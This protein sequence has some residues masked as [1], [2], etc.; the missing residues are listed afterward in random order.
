MFTV[1]TPNSF[2]VS[3]LILDGNKDSITS[4]SVNGGI[5]NIAAGKLVIADGAVLRNSVT[6][7][8]GGAVYVANGA[9]V[10]MTGGE[11]TGNEAVNGGAVYVEAGATMT[12]K[13]GKDASNNAT[14][15]TITG[16]TAT[17]AGA[18]IY[19]D[20][21]DTAAAKKGATL[22]L[23]GNPSFGGTGR[24]GENVDAEII[25][26]KTVGDKIV[27]IGN[28]LEGGLPEGT[29]NGQKEYTKFR[30]DIYVAGYLGT[31][32][33]GAAVMP[34]PATAIVVTGPI[35]SDAGSIWVA[36]EKPDADEANNHYEMLKQFAVFA[37][38]IA[39]DE[40]T[41]QVFRNAWDDE[42]TGCG[43][44]Y[45]TG[46]EGDNLTDED[47]KTWKCIYWTGGF[48]FVF[49]KI[50]PNGDAL[51]GA[52]FTLYLSNGDHTA[53]L[54]EKDE[55]ENDVEVAFQQTPEGGGDK[56]P[57]TAES[58]AIASEDA[59]AI[60]VNTGTV[61]NP[62][63]KNPDPEVYGEGLVVFKKIP[64]GVYFIKENTDSDGTVTINST[65]TADDGTETTVSKKYKP[66]GDMYM[67]DINGKGFYTIYVANKVNDTIVWEE[68]APVTAFVPNSGKYTPNTG[69]ASVTPYKKGIDGKYSLP[70]GTDAANP[71]NVP[72]P[73]MLNQSAQNRKVI[74][75]KVDGAHATLPGAK[76]TV[77]TFDKRVVK[78]ENTGI[79]ESLENLTSG[80]GG[81]FWIGKLPYGTYYLH[82]TTVPS[83]YKTITAG[84]D[85]NWFILTVNEDGVGYLAENAVQGTKPVNEIKAEPNKP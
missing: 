10:E 13:D 53:I 15:A 24:D 23:S 73:T 44:D 65:K 35:T 64:P 19:L 38:G 28:F 54:T 49:R 80:A 71:N 2:T 33:T 82:E 57:A 61:E 79:E 58:K 34:K 12:L 3:N 69:T 26:E 83:G 75:R 18:G 31:V 6:T 52:S 7:G 84:N 62:V 72:I 60:K 43:A 67:V 41:M 45:L 81:A 40:T 9:T 11:I 16:N 68:P 4:E 1:Y 5:I 48:D 50:G 20:Y 27:A 25:T 66:V 37:D 8:N 21:D 56:G 42:I 46:Q 74:L 78:V 70:A 85:G 30:Q 39:A 32:G 51:N 14:H 22:K 36:A 77:C 76:F 63:L 55:D 17:T 47:N 59:V 29:Q